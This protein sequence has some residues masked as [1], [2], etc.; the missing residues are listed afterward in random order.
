MVME[1]WGEDEFE[2][3][4]DMQLE[5]DTMT[6]DEDYCG[7]SGVLTLDGFEYMGIGYFNWECPTCSTSHTL[8]DTER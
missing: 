1:P 5:C 4:Q 3:T 8:E 7:W 2:I 6:S